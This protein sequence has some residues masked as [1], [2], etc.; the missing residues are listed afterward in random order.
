MKR[1]YDPSME[2]PAEIIEAALKIDRYFQ[3]QGIEK[4]KLCGVQSRDFSDEE[5][6]MK[7]PESSLVK[8]SQG[9][10]RKE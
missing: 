3:R 1:E 5:D 9:K 7:W 4:W 2:V 6:F 8:D 10:W